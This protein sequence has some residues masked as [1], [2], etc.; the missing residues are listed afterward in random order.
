MLTSSSPQ[1]STS[2]NAV[3]NTRQKSQ[4]VSS[5]LYGGGRMYGG[6]RPKAHCNWHPLTSSAPNGVDGGDEGRQ[7]QHG[8]GDGRGAT[9]DVEVNLP[10][11][12]HTPPIRPASHGASIPLMP[13]SRSDKPIAFLVDPALSLRT[14]RLEWVRPPRRWVPTRFRWSISQ[15]VIRVRPARSV[16]STRPVMAAAIRRKQCQVRPSPSSSVQMAGAHRTCD[17]DLPPAR[18]DGAVHRLCASTPTHTGER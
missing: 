5:K 7:L 6:S 10:I 18:R 16:K 8:R 1:H 11:H 2:G 13:V 3:H 17:E 4:R 14:C 9:I 15:K 12:T